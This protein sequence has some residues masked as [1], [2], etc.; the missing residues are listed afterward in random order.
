MPQLKITSVITHKIDYDDWDKFVKKRFPNCPYDS[1]VSEEEL[2]NDSTWSC[3]AKISMNEQGLKEIEAY[4]LE[5]EDSFIGIGTRHILNYLAY[6]GEIPQ[7]HYNI[8][9]CW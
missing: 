7:G 6:K 4:L 2:G 9:I 3:E 5:G 1:I 8:D